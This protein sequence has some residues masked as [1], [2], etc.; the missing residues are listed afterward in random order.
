VPP[1]DS[2]VAPE[3]NENWVEAVTAIAER[4]TVRGDAMSTE[5]KRNPL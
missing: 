2:G 1:G 5:T 4:G 3:V